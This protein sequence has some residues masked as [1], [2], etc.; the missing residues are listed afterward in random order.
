M[1]FLL[2]AA[3]GL[4]AAAP[5]AAAPP[6]DLG[7][8]LAEGYARPAMAR[9]DDSARVMRQDLRAWCASP[10]QEGAA[11]VAD[12]FGRLAQAWAGVAFLRFGP[13]VDGNRF[14]RLS[15][16]P[17]TRGVMPRQVQGALA[18]ADPALLAEGALKG[19]SVAVQGLPALEYLL[20]GEP[21]LL[22][23]A[24][25]DAA[26]SAY[27]CAYAVA[28]AGNIQGLAGEL[29]QAWGGQG[30]FGR[31]FTAPGPDN[32][33]YRS[34]QEV[35]AE[36]MKA[37]STGLQFAREV[38]LLPAL[39]ADAQAARPKRAAFWRS[40]QSTAVLAAS[41]RGLLAFYQA[42]G[43]V[44]APGSQGLADTFKHELGQ[45]EG[46]VAAAPDDAE[47]AFTQGE[48]RAALTLA[49]MILKNAKDVIDQD[50][51]PALG[52]TIGFNALDGD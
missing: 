23:H 8:R 34:A 46:L 25:R 47:A 6:A 52:V 36:A 16:W 49:A 31:Q 19:R 14:E 15:F 1:K 22:R 17:D 21:G 42:G 51:A 39:G 26:G 32:A 38:S 12:A 30:V 50:I 44:F 40:G 28:V 48:A 45:A 10:G 3:A 9:L 27:A 4:L 18:A 43:Y 20:Y 13:L 24:A 41:L 29:R 11:K 33:L 7:R 37:L 2:L 35:A 5:A